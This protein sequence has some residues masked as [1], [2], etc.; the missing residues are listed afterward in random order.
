MA[1]DAI[2]ELLLQLVS[3]SGAASTRPRPG[4]GWDGDPDGT[5]L[6]LELHIRQI[7]YRSALA[8]TARVAQPSLADFLR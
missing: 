2:G 6:L 5:E 3:A 8:V 7:G 1:A 4:A